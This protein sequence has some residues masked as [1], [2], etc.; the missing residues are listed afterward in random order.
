MKRINPNTDEEFRQGD[1]REDGYIF[2]SYRTLKN[3][4]GYFREDW[5]HPDVFKRKNLRKSTL[6]K[7]NLNL[8]RN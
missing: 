1:V 5:A 7:N 6:K 8:L 3:S 2:V 4:D